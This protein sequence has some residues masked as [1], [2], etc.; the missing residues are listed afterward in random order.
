MTTTPL[1]AT[2]SRG[3]TDASQ[4]A[5]RTLDRGTVSIEARR[6]AMAVL[7]EAEAADIAARLD[8]L[9]PLPA[10]DDIRRPEAGLV[11]VQGRIGGDGRAFNLGEA[12]VTRTAVRLA[13]G[14]VGFSCVLGRDGAKARLVALCDALMQSDLWRTAVETRVVAPL[15]E[16]LEAAERTEAARTAATRVDFFTLVRGED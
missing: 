6:A 12:T 1:D 15:R 3:T 8:T 5:G 13:G 7:V 16:T 9:G 11:M 10:H 4:T 2:P 14:E